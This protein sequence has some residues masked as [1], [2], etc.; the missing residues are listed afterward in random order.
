M[1]LVLVAPACGTGPA[2][3]SAAPLQAI[4]IKAPYTAIS[5]AQSPVWVAK[6]AGLFDKYG[7]DAE[8]TYIATSTVLTSAML[9]GEVQIAAAAEEAVISADLGGADLGTDFAARYVLT[10]NNLSPERDVAILQLGGVP[11]ILAGLKAGAIDAGVLSPPTTFTAKKAGL[12]ELVDISRE[13]LPFYQG[14][15][16]VRKSWLKD[17]RDTALRYLKAYTAAIALMHRDATQAKAIISTYSKVT[18]PEILSD[19]LTALL[20][21]LPVDQT[22]QL[23]AVRT[24]LEQTTLTNPRAKDAD[25]KQFIDAS[26]MQELV[27]SGFISGLK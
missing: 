26:L 20:K 14:P 15:I 13:E 23:S 18:D 3:T 12:K 11:E 25:P 17:H 1:A 9:S 22:P 10:H 27:K 2:A 5:V 7:L 8:L 24:G 21:I 6:E 16:I 4:K 19:S